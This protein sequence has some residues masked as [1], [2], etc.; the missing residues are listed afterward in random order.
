MAQQKGLFG[1][2]IPQDGNVLEHYGALVFRVGIYIHLHDTERRC[3]FLHVLEYP[4]IGRGNLHKHAFGD[5]VCLF[6][7]T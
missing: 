6:N 3:R 1:L 2:H 7:V 5:I 4:A